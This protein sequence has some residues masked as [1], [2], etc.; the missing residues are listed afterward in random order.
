VYF[1]DG[2][3]SES[4]LRAGG[5]H[6]TPEDGRS[7]HLIMLNRQRQVSSCVWYMEHHNTTSWDQL[8]VRSC[9]PALDAESSRAVRDA[10]NNQLATARQAKLSFAELGGWAVSPQS[11]CSTE[12][13]TLALAAYSLGRLFGGALG[14]TTAT[15]RHSSAGIRRLGGTGLESHGAVVSPYY[16]PRYKC[17]MELLRF[18]SRRPSPRYERLISLLKE[19]LAS[20]SVILSE[21]DHSTALSA[22]A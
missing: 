18:D 12:G 22:V 5:L 9:P 7:W 8:R 6:A 1:E 16:D 19:Q 15:V 2:A 4:D 10:V 17:H 11:R 21:L 13:L 14:L 3:L 20:V